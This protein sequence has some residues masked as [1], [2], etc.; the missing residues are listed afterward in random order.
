MRR[1]CVSS[2]F[3][4]T[5]RSNNTGIIFGQLGITCGWKSPGHDPRYFY[6]MTGLFLLTSPSPQDF[7]LACAYCGAPNPTLRLSTASAA[8]HFLPVIV[9]AFPLSSIGPMHV[10]ASPVTASGWSASIDR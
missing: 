8:V 6:L 2:H 5:S 1:V 7:G 9:V 4:S 3:T 10:A